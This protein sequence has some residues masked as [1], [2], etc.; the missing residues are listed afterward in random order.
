MFKDYILKYGGLV[1][2]VYNAR[3]TH[4][5]VGTQE[6]YIFEKVKII[7]IFFSHKYIIIYNFIFLY[8]L[9]RV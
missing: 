5:I 4:V 8:I 3:I 9:F 1:E 2:P 7:L 6:N